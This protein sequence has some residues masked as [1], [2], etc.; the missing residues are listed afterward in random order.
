[1]N[2]KKFAVV[3]TALLVLPFAAQAQNN[4]SYD[5]AANKV[6]TT[7]SVGI[8][9]STTPSQFNIFNSVASSNILTATTNSAYGGSMSLLDSS[10]ARYAANGGVFQR[11][12]G[13]SAIEISNM[14]LGWSG[15]AVIYALD[16]RVLWINTQSGAG[17]VYIGN[18]QS[19]TGLVVNGGG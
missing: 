14:Q 19:P 16:G 15:S 6:T 18:P 11:F 17:D 7:S 5:S 4:W 1:M 8:G 9:T 3:L 12:T 10:S 2:T 13:N